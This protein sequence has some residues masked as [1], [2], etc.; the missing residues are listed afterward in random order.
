MTIHNAERAIIAVQ[1]LTEYLL[2]MSHK[3]RRREGEASAW[4]RVSTR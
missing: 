3:A 1:K 2:N 4:R